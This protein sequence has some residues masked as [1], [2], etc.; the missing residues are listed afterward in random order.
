MRTVAKVKHD[1]KG[2]W[3]NRCVCSSAM[4]GWYLRGTCARWR[5]EPGTTTRACWCQATQRPGHPCTRSDICRSRNSA[6]SQSLG[7]VKRTIAAA[8][9]S[10][11]GGGEDS[12]HSQSRTGGRHEIGVSNAPR[13]GLM[14]SA[15]KFKL[16]RYPAVLHLDQHRVTCPSSHR[17][18]IRP[19][20]TDD[21]HRSHGFQSKGEIDNDRQDHDRK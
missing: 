15:W 9:D 11:G 13:T 21:G 12:R 18:A 16:T 2:L 1:V 19:T 8:L 17:A 3:L 7:S 14:S 6:C 20:H 4:R 10:G 5:A